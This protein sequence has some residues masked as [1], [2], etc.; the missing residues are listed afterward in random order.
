MIFG[1]H[2]SPYLEFLFFKFTE[3]I[4]LDSIHDFDFSLRI[5]TCSKMPN[6]CEQVFIFILN[7]HFPSS[8]VRENMSAKTK[9][10]HSNLDHGYI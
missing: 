6:L 2:H 9:P 3:C 4:G 1:S 7:W 10:L 5:K 8:V